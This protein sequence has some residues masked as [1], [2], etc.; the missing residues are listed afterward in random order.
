MERPA[1]AEF[2]VAPMVHVTH[3]HFRQLMRLISSRATLWTEMVHADARLLSEPEERRRRLD[4]HPA[5]RPIVL[6]LAGSYPGQVA[7][8]TR[9]ALPWG[10]D[11]LNLNCGCPSEERSDEPCFGARLMQDS[12]RAAAVAGAMCAA[13]GSVPVSVKC[14]LA[15]RT[16]QELRAAGSCAEDDYEALRAFVRRVSEV[17]VR[18]FYVHARAGVLGATT[19]WNR[20]APPLRPELALRLAEEHPEL[21]VVVNGGIISPADA[22][23]LRHPRLRGVMVA[24]AVRSRPYLWSGLDA[25]WFGDEAAPRSRRELLEAYAAYAEDFLVSAPA[26]DPR[27]YLPARTGLGVPLL[28]LFAGEPGADHWQATIA[29]WVHAGGEP[30][31]RALRE[32]IQEACLELEAAQLDQRGAASPPAMARLPPPLAASVLHVHPGLEVDAGEEA[33]GA[34][35]AYASECVDEG[36][37]LLVIAPSRLP[38]EA[39]AGLLGRMPN[40]ATSRVRTEKDACFLGKRVPG[41]VVLAVGSVC[42]LATRPIPAGQ[43]VVVARSAA[44]GC[45]L[46]LV[47][48]RPAAA[49]PRV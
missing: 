16:P 1:A 46:E 31:G 20:E 33:S 41:S 36:T 11:E 37:V 35:R 19:Y 26:P 6:Q 27:A 32:A 42:V 49:A 5:Q 9:L 47:G 44:A 12:A 34:L 3:R 8:A 21:E 22:A 18:R 45:F 43:P 38:K 23:R 24:R 48:R 2:H 30:T 13:A 39:A 28:N 14:R 10:Y 40:C 17:G 7:E 29:R 15:V 4:F 25:D